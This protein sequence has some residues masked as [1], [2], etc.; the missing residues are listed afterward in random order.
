MLVPLGALDAPRFER[1]WTREGRHRHLAGGNM[2]G[3]F[4]RIAVVLACL[5]ALAACSPAAPPPATYDL[6]I[7]NGRVRDPASGLDG[8]RQVGITG[9][10]IGTIS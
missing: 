5:A 8:V 3:M 2:C 9:G 7:A 4:R 1:W 6:V 10:R